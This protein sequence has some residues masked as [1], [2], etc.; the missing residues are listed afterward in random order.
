MCVV[1]SYEHDGMKWLF[2][3]LLCRI[4]PVSLIARGDTVNESINVGVVDGT[5]VTQIETRI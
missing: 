2:I 3:M 5:S 1:D 4:S